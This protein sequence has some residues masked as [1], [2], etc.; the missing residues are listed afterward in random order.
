MYQQRYVRQRHTA[1]NICHASPIS[2]RIL[3]S[4]A[5]Y[6]CNLLRG[7]SCNK[8]RSKWSSRALSP[9]TEPKAPRRSCSSHSDSHPLA[10]TWLPSSASKRRNE[11]S[12]LASCE[13]GGA[14]DSK[15]FDAKPGKTTDLIG[16]GGAPDPIRCCAECSLAIIER[17]GSWNPIILLIAS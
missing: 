13:N 7:A 4:S 3:K 14:C 5:A 15:W 6:C 10:Y 17:C 1:R 9:A 11:S 12:S 16:I 8:P 2:Q